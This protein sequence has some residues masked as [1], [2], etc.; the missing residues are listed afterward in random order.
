M[1][2]AAHSGKTTD[3]ACS[4]Y[5]TTQR[6][7]ETLSEQFHASSADYAQTQ[8]AMDARILDTQ[9]SVQTL[10]I[11]TNAQPRARI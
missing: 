11:S 7:P 2:A 1:I 3:N 9:Q 10:F 8:G 5:P 6:E 4:I